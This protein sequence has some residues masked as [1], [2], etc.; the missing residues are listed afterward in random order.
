MKPS[1]IILL[2]IMM[3]AWGVTPTVGKF[4]VGQIPPIFFAA[5]RAG[6][7]M[8]VL[9]P[10]L[11]N[12]RGH[13]GVLFLLSLLMGTLHH[14]FFLTGLKHLDAS[15]TIILAQ[16]QFPFAALLAVPFFGDY[17]GWRRM[18]GLAI[19]FGGIVLIAGEPKVQAEF[20]PAAF[21]LFA[22]FCWA[23]ANIVIKRMRL[24]DGNMINGWVAILM[25]PQT[26]AVSFFLESGQIAALMA[27]DWKALAALVYMG[28]FITAITFALWYR[29]LRRYTVN[30]VMPFTLLMPVF[31]VLAGVL[32]LNEALSWLTILGGLI[33]IAGVAII[34]I[35][36]PME[37]EAGV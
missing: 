7:T 11:R 33:T 29:L 1:H 34:V 37:I 18:G 36:R 24:T 25:V 16:M 2:V 13:W 17:L 20:L 6:V 26:L 31:G 12:P 32:V 5:L 19:A 9:L 4:G 22:V 10:F 14:T 3:V 8:L 23:A 15:H 28:G 30:Q 27:A 21:V 35:R